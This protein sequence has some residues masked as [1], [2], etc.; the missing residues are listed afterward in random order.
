MKQVKLKVVQDNYFICVENNESKLYGKEMKIVVITPVRNGVPYLDK[1]FKNIEEFADGVVFVEDGSTDNTYDVIKNHPLTKHVIRNPKRDSYT[2]WN[3]SK[4]LH[5]LTEYV[6]TE[7]KDYD[8]ILYMAIDE[9][10]HPTHR[11]K[12]LMN[13]DHK[14]DFGFIFSFHSAGEDEKGYLPSGPHKFVYSQEIPTRRFEHPRMWQNKS[15]YTIHHT[16]KP[17]HTLEVPMQLKECFASGCL[18]IHRSSSTYDKRK[19][20]YDKYTKE[21][22]PNNRYQA[23]YENIHPNHKKY[24]RSPICF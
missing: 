7:M 23:S 10:I 21:L 8:W 6:K 24:K 5:R 12:D 15:H 11:I 22:D 2:G 4:N 20:R 3:A 18:L 16:G 14:G 19:E 1:Y 9:V 17:L 13:F